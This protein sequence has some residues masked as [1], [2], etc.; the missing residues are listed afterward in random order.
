MGLGV[1]VLPEWLIE[2]DLVSG[3]LVRVVAQV[4]S[5]GFT[6][7]RR[8]SRAAPTTGA[9]QDIHRFCRRLH[10]HGAEAQQ[11]LAGQWLPPVMQTMRESGEP[12]QPFGVAMRLIIEA[13]LEGARSRTAN[14]A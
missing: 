1:A 9:S 13:R 4:A 8:L 3:R 7:S 11:T 5:Q 10:E 6:R 12:C 2:D 14:L